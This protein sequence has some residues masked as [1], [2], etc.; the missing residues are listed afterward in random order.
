MTRRDASFLN[1]DNGTRAPVF[2]KDTRKTVK[3]VGLEQVS[4]PS[5]RDRRRGWV[6]E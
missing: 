6:P 2:A 3:E 4:D 1:L 5:L